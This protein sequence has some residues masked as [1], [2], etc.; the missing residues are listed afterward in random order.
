MPSVTCTIIAMN[1][2]DRIANTIQS[3]QGLVS[4]VL[5]IDGGSS[6][7]TVAICEGLGARVIHNPW[8]GFGPQKRV[9][10]EQASHDWILN[11]DADECLSPELYR[12]IK[13]LLVSDIP[14]ERVFQTRIRVVYPK[15]EMPAPF[16]DF[17]NYIRLYNRTSTR[18]R[19]SLT[20]DE[21]LPTDDVVQLRGEILHRS[22]RSVSHIV[23]KF[24][25]YAELQ[26]KER[27]QTRRIGTFRIAVELP[28]QFFKYYFLRRHVFGGRAGFVYAMTLAVSRWLRLVMIAGW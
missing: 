7:N 24:L 26:K 22:Y 20:H 16:A 19:N 23:R 6:D 21:V 9:A 17:H 13:Q 27:G 28:F 8:H 15:N 25:D 10:E 1:E 2:A 3:V 12:E 4:E 5:V 14:T 18:F 11:L